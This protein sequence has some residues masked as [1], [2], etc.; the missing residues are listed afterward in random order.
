MQNE[1][2]E[3]LRV[4]VVDDHPMF[5]YGLVRLLDSYPDLETAGQ[6]SNGREAVELAVELQPDVVVMDLNMPELDGVEATR[7]ITATA[8]HIGVLVLTM[9][10]DDETVF[11]AIRAGALGYY[12]KGAD[13][14]EILRAIRVVGNREAI[15]GP[16]I[17]QRILAYFTRV[18]RSATAFPQLTDRERDVLHLIAKG[19][20]NEEIAQRLVLSLKTVR[21]HVSNIY[22]KL[23]VADRSRAIVRAREAGFGD[24]L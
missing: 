17:A 24:P 12:L 22:A 3:P 6:A 4:L 18:P 5:R 9:L 1:P 15:Y 7:R 2:V 8:P 10:D 20:R 11:S 16:A 13:H 23:H 19:R 14:E 21:N